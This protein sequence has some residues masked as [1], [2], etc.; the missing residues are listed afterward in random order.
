M[1]RMTMT[2]RSSIRVKPCSLASRFLIFWITVR[3]PLEGDRGGMPA[4][5]VSAAVARG[6][7]PRSGEMIQV[8]QQPAGRDR[9]IPG[10]NVR[11]ARLPAPLEAQPT[12]GSAGLRGRL[13]RFDGAG[14]G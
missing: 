4:G 14:A 7:E 10:A 2:T 5:H 11:G 12:A 1:P 8:G 13:S 3:S 6:P 9:S